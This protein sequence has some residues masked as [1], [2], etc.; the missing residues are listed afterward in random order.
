MLGTFNFRQTSGSWFIMGVTPAQGCVEQVI[1]SLDGCD[2]SELAGLLRI[3]RRPGYSGGE[4][5]MADLGR[6]PGSLND[7]DLA[8]ISEKCV[9]AGLTP[10]PGSL[11]ASE[12]A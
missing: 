9:A 2:N 6:W 5:Y 7:A 4:A 3:L 8:V 11:S 10:A 1:E 12:A